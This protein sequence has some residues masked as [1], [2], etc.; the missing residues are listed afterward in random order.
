MAL[1]ESTLN[2]D[3]LATKGEEIYR[4]DVAPR[5]RP[6]DANKFVAIDVQSGSFEISDDDYTA[7]ERLLAGRPG[8]RIWLARVGQPAAYRLGGALAGVAQ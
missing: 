8:A 1:S 6:Q 7:T 5:L 3:E 4:R 2:R